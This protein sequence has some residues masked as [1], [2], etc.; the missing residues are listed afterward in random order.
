M[1]IIAL[2]EGP[3]RFNALQREI[4]ISAKVL[5]ETLRDLERDGLV[6]RNS[7]AE[8]P[9]RVEYELTRLG[10]TLQGPLTALRAWAEEHIDDVLDAREA[11]DLK[12]S[13]RL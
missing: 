3:M 4:G 13:P 5:T 12:V 8:V 1:I 11:Y 10:V 6:R 7:Y 2:A 9:R